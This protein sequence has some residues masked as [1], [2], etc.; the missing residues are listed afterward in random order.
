MIHVEE[1]ADHLIRHR[2]LAGVVRHVVS[3]CASVFERITQTVMAA[4]EK[5]ATSTLSF[6][7]LIVM[8]G[9]A[10][11]FG[12][13]LRTRAEGF[14]QVGPPLIVNSVLTLLLLVFR[15]EEA[16]HAPRNPR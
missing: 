6:T 13:L 12:Y 8:A 16:L 7:V 3:V 9:N 5:D 11:V 10:L 2:S 14:P 4:K 1:A 15:K